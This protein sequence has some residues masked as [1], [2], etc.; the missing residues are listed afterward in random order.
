MDD[1]VHGHCTLLEWS[2]QRLHVELH[3]LQV[4]RVADVVPIGFD[5]YRLTES[6]R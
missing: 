5:W 1:Y 2:G 4:V 6:P 3:E